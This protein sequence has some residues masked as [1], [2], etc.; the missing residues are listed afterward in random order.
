M[1][2]TFDK[3]IKAE[4]DETLKSLER[5]GAVIVAAIALRHGRLKSAAIDFGQSN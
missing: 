5:A 3:M 4:R 1:P 2:A